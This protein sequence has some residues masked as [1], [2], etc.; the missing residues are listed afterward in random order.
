MASTNQLIVE[1]IEMALFGKNLEIISKKNSP[2]AYILNE[3]IGSGS[4]GKVFKAKKFFK[5]QVSNSE[6][7][8][9]TGTELE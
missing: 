9:R 8:Y 1:K 6:E 4:Y 7:M 2:S 5:E 3:E